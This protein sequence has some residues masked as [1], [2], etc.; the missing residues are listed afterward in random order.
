MK[1]WVAVIFA[2]LLATS[3]ATQSGLGRATTLAPGVSQFTPAVEFSLVSVKNE[4]SQATT[5]PWM[6]LGVGFHRGI[7]E[8]IELGARAWGFGWPNYL[9]TAGICFDSKFQVYK[10]ARWHVAL[11]PSLK[12]HAVTLAAAP[13]HIFGLEIPVLLGLNLGKHQLVAGVR[14]TDTFLTGVGTNPINAAWVGAHMAV[15]FRLPKAVELMPEL[16]ILYS[17]VPF[18]GETKDASRNGASIIH[19]GI[20]VNIESSR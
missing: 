16:G 13:W 14:V 6:L 15:S 10:G 12:Y 11:A 18:N 7:T 1:I 8:R 20:G 19:F 4:A 2:A 5:A 9:T 17:P 3:C